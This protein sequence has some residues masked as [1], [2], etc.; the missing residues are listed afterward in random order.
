MSEVH[1]MSALTFA[2]GVQCFDKMAA[3]DLTRKR[4]TYA[5]LLAALGEVPSQA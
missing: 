5:P 1:C 3:A 2:S 4:R